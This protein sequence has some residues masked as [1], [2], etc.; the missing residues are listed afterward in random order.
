MSNLLKVLVFSLVMIGFF[1]GYSNFGIPQIEPSPPPEP[2]VLDL[3]AMTMTRFIAIGERVFD[4]RGTCALCHNE[5]GGRAPMLDNMT[6]ITPARLQEAS[7]KGTAV[8]VEGYLRESMTDPSVYVVSGFGK[9]GTND[10]ESPMPDVSGGSIGLTETEIDAVIAYLQDLAGAEVTVQLPAEQEE[11]S[12]LG[13]NEKSEENQPVVYSSAEEIIAALACGACHKI[14]D[15]Q[16]M[17]GPDLTAIGAARDLE[18]LRRAIL[19]PDA[20]VAQGSIAGVMPATYGDQLSANDL[21]MLLDY[22]AASGAQAEQ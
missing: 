7:Y 4:G 8:D 10:T 17:V 12:A 1:A 11:D 15:Q 21:E 20:D 3:S 2:E 6:E 14:A 16:G 22:M 19:D 5:V 9:A 18:Y 13:S